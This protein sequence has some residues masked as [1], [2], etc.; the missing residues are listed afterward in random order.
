MAPVLA[1]REGPWKGTVLTRLSK[2][3]PSPEA[4]SEPTMTPV[5][6]V[7]A[8]VI[9]PVYSQER[10]LESRSGCALRLG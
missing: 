9:I 10:W 8:E 1:E 7:G 3:I 2:R 6:A 4:P 5:R